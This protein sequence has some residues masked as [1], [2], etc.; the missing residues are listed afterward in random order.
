[1][2]IQETVIDALRNELQQYG[3]ML[4]LLDQQQEAVMLR[5]A[6]DILRSISAI[7]AQS[8]VVQ[9]ARRHRQRALH[10]LA[11]ALGQTAEASFADLV[12]L[13]ADHYRPLLTALIQ[14]NNELLFRVRQRAQQNHLL[15][16][17][18][19]DL[20]QRFLSTLDNQEAP[21][22]TADRDLLPQPGPTLCHAL[23]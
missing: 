3:E 5:G 23:A 12:P 19:L 17:Q 10:E 6:D 21:V 20:M 2:A 8:T 22:P 4:A 13:L 9:S 11:L 7:N 15:L 14:E 16:Q 18:S 1:M